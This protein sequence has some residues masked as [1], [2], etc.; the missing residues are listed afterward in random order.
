MDELTVEKRGLAPLKTD[1]NAISRLQSERQLAQIVGR[2]QLIYG[3]A[4]LFRQGST[5]FD[6]T[7]GHR[8]R[9]LIA[10]LD[11]DATRKQNDERGVTFQ[12]PQSTR[13]N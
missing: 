6:L 11:L 7:P 10:D 3:S 8:R 5:L 1:L 13:V 4:I 12:L 2:L 9:I